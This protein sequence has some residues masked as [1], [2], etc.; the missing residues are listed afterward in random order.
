MKKL[1]ISLLLILTA[2]VFGCGSE[3]SQNSLILYSELDPKFTFEMVRTFMKSSRD[4][5][6]L[7]K[8]IYELKD[9]G[10]RPDIVLAERRTLN[11]LVMDSKLKTTKLDVGNDLPVGFR[12]G[13]GYW[14]GI[15]Y[16]P[17]VFL[18][19][20][21]YARTI[22]QKS[23]R[24]WSDL[25]NIPNPR[26]C[27]ENLS[28]NISS[29]NFLGALADNMGEQTTLTYLWNLNR[30][31]SDYTNFP[32]STVRKTAVGD[33][34]IS[35]TRQSI[36]F[37]YL[38]SKFPAY[39]VRPEEGTPV[40]LF[41]MGLFKDCANEEKAH[42]F[43]EW[44]MTS[45][46]MKTFSQQMLTGYEFLFDD[47]GK[48]TDTNKLWLNNSYMVWKEQEYLTNRWLDMVRFSK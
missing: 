32:F 40:N 2:A 48:L 29:Q 42:I 44:M 39:I 14:Y 38:E 46:D 22:G 5:K 3:K 45:P 9:D 25:Q 12:D 31:V 35:I 19:N 41:C 4:D 43:M 8:V 11:G 16:D 21:N 10:P 1:L 36:V 18:V 28:N 34:D 47:G 24:K 23:I 15:F 7:I 20:Q 17:A 6:F 37:K 27:I 13:E 33:T 30:F 26:I